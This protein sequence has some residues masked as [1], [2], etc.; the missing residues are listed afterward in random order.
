[1]SVLFF[2]GCICYDAGTSGRRPGPGGGE[3]PVYRRRARAAFFI[4]AYLFLYPTHIVTVLGHV[5]GGQC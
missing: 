3:T 4:T 5:R 1:M 2:G